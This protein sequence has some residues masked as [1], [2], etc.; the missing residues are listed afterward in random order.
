MR[1]ALIVVGVLTL[2]VAAN[3][4]W[5]WTSRRRSL[6]CPS[7]LSWGVEGPFFSWLLRTETT[8]DRIH[9]HPGQRILEIGPG[10]GRLLLP[11]A[12]RI[13]PGGEA[14][15]IDIQAPMIASLKA[16][17]SNAGIDNLMGIV[18]DAAEAMAP[19]EHDVVLMALTLGEIPAA[20]Q[21]E[22]LEHAFGVLKPGGRLSIT[23][24]FPDPHFLSQKAVKRLA[25]AA[26]F[27]HQE[28]LGS[29]WFH[30]SNFLRPERQR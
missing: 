11:A 29:R 16:R 19:G 5:R 28:T 26:G 25:A 1:L 8:L 27:Q 13:S 24:M 20:R 14:V 7:W 15:G 10:P 23:E 18:G 3:I 17:A 22:A 12:R 4:A 30:T 21:L 6:P 9:L 2:I